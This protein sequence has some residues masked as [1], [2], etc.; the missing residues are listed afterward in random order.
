MIWIAIA[1]YVG[2]M[3]IANLTVY[4]FGPWLAPINS[5]FLI[6]LDLTL[7]DGLQFRSLLSRPAMALLI[8]GSSLLTYVL[9]PA[10]SQIAIASAV[11]FALAGLA[12]WLIFGLI[13]GAWLK[14]ANGANVVGSAVDS[15]V[16]PWLAFG[17]FLPLIVLGQFAAKV[18]GGAVW[19]LALNGLVKREA[20]K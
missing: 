17:A 7:R 10:A 16:F 15:I 13:K 19:A 20:R 1:V 6:G 11:A 4:A 18:I 5:F 3:V 8:V 14:R 2:A 12:D 9:N